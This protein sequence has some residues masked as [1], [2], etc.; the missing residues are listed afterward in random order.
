MSSAIIDMTELLARVEDDRE[1]MRDLLLIFKEEFPQHLAALRDAVSSMNA[2]KI[3]AEAHALKGMLSN[4]AAHPAA[5][6]AAR[7]ELL[8]RN[9]EVSQFQ[10]AFAS[11]EKISRELLLQL[12]T[13]M[14]EVSG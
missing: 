1:L 5:A 10:A 12:D 11:F 3:A 7:L 4:L 9:R 2:E 14:A 6:A 8:G 13:C